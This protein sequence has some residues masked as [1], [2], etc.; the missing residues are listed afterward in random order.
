MMSAIWRAASGPLEIGRRLIL[1]LA[2]CLWFGGFTFYS[3]VVI[4]TGHRVFHSRVE[5]GFLTQAVTGWLNL[6]GV[7]GLCLMLWN[8]FAGWSRQGRFVR[9]ALVATWLVVAG[10]EVALFMLHPK[11]DA[12]LDQE[13]HSIVSRGEF[14]S[15]H[16]LYMNLSTTQ[17]LATILYIFA[18]VWA[19]RQVD[20]AVSG[21]THEHPVGSL[22]GR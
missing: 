21:T 4:H 15:L 1:V 3:L 16:L 20:R 18:T 7:G 8:V 11:L 14:K 12:L 9:G 19:W 17:W 6:I 10:M 5:V 13:T 2:L 22:T